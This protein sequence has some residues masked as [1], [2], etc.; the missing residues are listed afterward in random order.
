[1]LNGTDALT[2]A[3]IKKPNLITLDINMPGLNGWDTLTIIKSDTELSDIPVVVITSEEE[4][5]KGL[6][7]GADEY[8]IKP[9]NKDDIETIFSRYVKKEE[10]S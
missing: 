3:R 10:G 4:R 5:K 8:L 6:D 9:I 7:L 1:A 2:K